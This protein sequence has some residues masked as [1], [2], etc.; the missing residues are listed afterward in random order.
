MTLQVDSPQQG[1]ALEGQGES[2]NP[3]D[4][5]WAT[6]RFQ[7]TPA[8]PDQLP[9][10]VLF[11]GFELTHA[12]LSLSKLRVDLGPEGFLEADGSLELDKPEEV[13]IEMTLRLEEGDLA[14]ISEELGL[15]PK[16]L[17]GRLSLQARLSG[18]LRAGEPLL[19]G[20]T[21]DVSLS[22]HNGN[23][24]KEAPLLVALTQATEGLNPFA[25]RD[26][27]HFES[28]EATLELDRGRVL[29][30]DFELEGPV[31]MRLSGWADYGRPSREIEGILGVFLFRR[32]DQI[33]GSL[34]VVKSFIPGSDKGLVG[35]YFEVS[36][37]LGE[38][39]LTSLPVKSLTEELPDILTTPLKAIR[40]LL[41]TKR[42][43]TKRWDGPRPG[44]PESQ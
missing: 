36:G 31:R 7:V 5:K 3:G 32:W 13:P 26:S 1:S 22:A 6:G 9:F 41:M 25:N 20:L 37:K 21:G 30:D 12:T 16:R 39:K 35:A 24:G 17:S 14:A 44:L 11:G 18:R 23:I 38:P 29:T 4:G 10:S 2:V 19:A 33:L 34:P 27:I 28:M 40:S 15:P 8:G 42:P 43:K